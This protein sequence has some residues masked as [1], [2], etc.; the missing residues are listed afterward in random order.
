MFGF[1]GD[2]VKMVGTVVGTVIGVPVA[3]VAETLGIT[4]D[5]VNEAKRAGCETYE[6]I[7]DFHK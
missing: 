7:R 2:I 3:I 6:E 5:M 1:L 4:I